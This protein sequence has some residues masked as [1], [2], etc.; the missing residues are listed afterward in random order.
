[1][2]EQCSEMVYMVDDDAAMRDS[3]TELVESVGMQAQTYPSAEA[4]LDVCE[5]SHPC[6]LVLDVRMPG[7]SGLTLLE[8]LQ[9]Q[10]AS[11]PVIL[12]TSHGDVPMAVD[13]MKGGAF[14]FVQKPY[15]DQALLDR[16]QAALSL[17]RDRQQ[18][19]ETEHRLGQCVNTLTPRE[20]HVFDQMLTGSTSKEI[21]RA[22]EISP[23][24]AEVHRRNVLRKFNVH[25][26]KA[27]LAL[28]APA[29]NP[30]QRES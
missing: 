7:M 28:F 15:R 14:D 17:D 20:R 4:F 26:T 24:T 9:G 27:L 1:M 3:I 6:C 2:T 22:L 11:L 30:A 10:G 5:P 29:S 23:R 25:S 21:A 13:S 12:L 8:R 18:V 19:R 16:I